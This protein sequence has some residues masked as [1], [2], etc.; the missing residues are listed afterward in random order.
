[1]INFLIASELSAFSRRN[2][3]EPG[4]L[5]TWQLSSYEKVYQRY[6]NLYNCRHSL[7]KQYFKTQWSLSQISLQVSCLILFFMLPTETVQCKKHLELLWLTVCSRLTSCGSQRK[8]QKATDRKYKH[9]AL[10]ITTGLWDFII[11][12]LKKHITYSKMSCHFWF[13]KKLFLCTVAAHSH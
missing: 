4:F 13:K 10:S 8:A 9:K 5:F 6:L 7:S 3:G 12:S 1:M 11:N 2:L